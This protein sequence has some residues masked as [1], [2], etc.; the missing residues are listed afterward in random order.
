MVTILSIITTFFLEEGNKIHKNKLEWKTKYFYF[1][2]EKV[3]IG[4]I[5]SGRVCWE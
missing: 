1:L 5:L 3:Y 2:M 4:K